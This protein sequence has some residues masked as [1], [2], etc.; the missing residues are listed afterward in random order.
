[1]LITQDKLSLFTRNWEVPDAK[2]NVFLVHGFVEHSGRYGE[3]ADFFNKKE[4]NVYS[5]DHRGH[6]KSEGERAYIS[7]FKLLADDM[8][9][10]MNSVYDENTPSFIF[11]HSLGALVCSYYLLLKKPVLKNMKGIM[12]TAPG[13]M[14]SKDLA[15][16]LQKLA[17][18]IGS[19]VPRMTTIGLDGEFI[20]KDPKIVEAYRAD[21]LV[22]HKKS[23]A[24]TGWEIMKAMKYVQQKASDFAYPLFLGHGTVDKL[25]ELEGSK[26]FYKN[27]SSQDKT[28]KIYEGLYHE[29]INEPEKEIVYKD[30]AAWLDPR[31]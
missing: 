27:I 14:V 3:L 6:G 16:L 20:S 2:A 22:Y 18:I 4:C 12:Y 9:L 11:A 23:H 24:R 25:A 19:L 15:P 30:L 21:P 13:L 5:Y 26:L 10:W 28:M 17:P 8:E 7:K 29:L 1:M 31:L